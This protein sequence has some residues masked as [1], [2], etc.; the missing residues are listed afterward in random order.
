MENATNRQTWTGPWIVP[1]S[2][3]SVIY[4]IPRFISAIFP[5]FFMR[6]DA[7]RR[8]ARIVSHG[9]STLLLVQLHSE[10]DAQRRLLNFVSS[11]IP[12][13]TCTKHGVFLWRHDG[14]RRNSWRWFP[15]SSQGAPA[16]NMASFGVA[17]P[18]VGFPT[19]C[20]MAF[21]GSFVPNVA[22]C[23]GVATLGVGFQLRVKKHSEA[24]LC[25]TWRL[26]AAARILA[27]IGVATLGVDFPTSCPM[28]SRDSSVP[29]RASCGGVGFPTSCPL[30][31]FV[32]SARNM[33]YC[34][35]VAKIGVAMFGVGFPAS[36]SV[37]SWRYLRKIWRL[38][39]G[40][41]QLASWRSASAC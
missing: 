10:D 3:Y 17:T 4:E 11:G 15:T 28:V 39:A 24:H 6:R 30:A 12:R 7:R 36:F 2:R 41:W 29:K 16:L 20:P 31:S 13:L 14:W 40:S 21:R 38:L 33:P 23:V 22:S 1:C 19:S 18:D 9:V 37:T 27:M 34:V 8:F 35:G 32:S 26:L 5:I 25:Q